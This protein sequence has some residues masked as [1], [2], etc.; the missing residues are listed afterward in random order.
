[1]TDEAFLESLRPT[2]EEVEQNLGWRERYEA[3]GRPSESVAPATPKLSAEECGKLISNEA[4][5]LVWSFE[6]AGRKGYEQKYCHPCRPPDP[7]GIT[8]GLGYDLGYCTP[9]EFADDWQPLLSAEDA[10]RLADTVGRKS[11]AAQALLGDVRDIVVAWDPAEAVYRKKTVPKYMN[12]VLRIFPGAETLHPHCAGALFS[13]VYNRGA[14]MS[15]DGRIEMRAIADAIRAGRPE[16]VPNEFRKMKRLWPD[17]LGL[18]RR[19]DAEAD[20]FGR[21]VAEADRLRREVPVAVAM[22]SVAANGEGGDGRLRESLGLG[23]GLAPPA[24]DGD[25]QNRSTDDYDPK[26]P[27]AAAPNKLE[28]LPGWA[29][30]RWVED[31][32]LSTE[33]R[34]IEAGDRWLKDTGFLFQASDLELLIRANHFRPLRTEKRIIFGLRGALLDHDT[35]NPADGAAQ[36]ARQSLRLKV[37]RPDHQNFRCVVGVFDTETNLL[38]GFLATTVP[39]RLA[40]WSHHKG[41]EPSNM[42]ACGSYRY[43][44]GPHKGNPGCLRQDEALCVLRSRDNVVYDVKDT[45]DAKTDP[46]SWPMDNIHPACA[47]KQHSA[48]F[49]SWGCQTPRG[50][51]GD[52]SFTDEFAKFRSALG[53]RKPGTDNNRLFTYVLLTGHEAA[54]AA[55]LRTSGRDTDH[56]AVRA[57]LVRLRQGSEGEPVRR[58]QAALGLA[59]DGRLGATAKK[60]LADAQ[61]KRS[62]EMAGDGVYAPHFDTDWGLDVFGAADSAPDAPPAPMVVAAAPSGTRRESIGAAAARPSFEAVLF[63]IGRRAELAAGAPDLLAVAVV[64]QYEAITRESWQGTVARG[65]RVFDRIERA[66][67]ELICGDGAADKADRERIQMA[68]GAASAGGT[69]AL[70][71][72]LAGI[73]TAHLLIPSVLARPVAEIIVGRAVGHFAEGS[74]QTSLAGFCAAWGR[75]L[76]DAAIP[77]APAGA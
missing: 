59:V 72:V 71:P 31:D 39:N 8:I 69:A 40:V 3:D 14:K 34:H 57:S 51:F 26:V 58:L 25:G 61:R 49:S 45:W 73:L 64:P 53:L 20:L 15:G 4:H 13:L 52:G 41:G 5:D 50:W 60:A 19:R 32:D 63:E 54:I 65:Q 56:A 37:C 38:S 29:A 36:V 33:F 62:G 10:G 16:Q 46:G 44:V 55:H 75:R 48:L 42:L 76:Y 1:M 7:S 22:A 21:G 28:A 27:F 2:A 70:V 11:G 9:L 24:H 43:R 6:V 66:A 77:A 67:H 18:R 12:Q 74:P 35:S 68:L 30:V 17:L 23:E 47:D